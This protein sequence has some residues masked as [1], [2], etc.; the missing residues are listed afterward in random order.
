MPAYGHAFDSLKI[1]HCKDCVEKF[2]GNNED[3]LKWLYATF[4]QKPM[5]EL[6]DALKR[7]HEAV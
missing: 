5:T 7:K 2:V 3:E 6:T 1:K 4:L